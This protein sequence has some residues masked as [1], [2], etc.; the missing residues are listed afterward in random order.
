MTKKKLSSREKF[1]T[2]L[3]EESFEQIRELGVIYKLDNKNHVI[4]KALQNE[5]NRLI[6]KD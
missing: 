3:K 2:T 5:Y 1:T 4:E 6:K